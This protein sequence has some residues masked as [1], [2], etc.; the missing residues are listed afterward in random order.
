MAIFFKIII[1]VSVLIALVNFL[2]KSWFE[3]I[4]FFLFCFWFY[5]CLIYNPFTQAQINCMIFVGIPFLCIF[6]VFKM[7]LPKKYRTKSITKNRRK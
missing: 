3:L 1:I 2:M 6:G 5:I 4:L 7:T